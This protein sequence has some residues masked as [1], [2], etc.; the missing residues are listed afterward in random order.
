MYFLSIIGWLVIS[1]N[2]L[3]NVLTLCVLLSS[4]FFFILRVNPG[5]LEQ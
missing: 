2:N 3:Y 1:S 4:I 5:Y